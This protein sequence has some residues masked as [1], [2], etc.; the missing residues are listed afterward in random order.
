MRSLDLTNQKMIDARQAFMDALAKND[1]DALMDAMQ[2]M[3]DAHAQ[4]LMADY[5]DLRQETD[6]RILAQRGVR[7]LT[8]EERKYYQKVVEAMKSPDP[9]QAITNLEA[10]M[11]TTIIDAVFEDLET[12]H[13]LLS[14]IDFIP[15]NGLIEMIMNTDT[16]QMATWGPL[17]G[18][19]TKELQTGFKKEATNLFKLSAFLPVC[20]AM[21]DLGPVWLD[22]YVRRVLAEALANGLEYGY[23]MGN[24]KDMPIGMVR[25]AGEGV[26]VT[27]GV[28]PEKAAIELVEINPETIGNLLSIMAMGPN[29]KTRV[30]NGVI[31][32]VNGQD[33]YQKVMPATTVMAPDGTYRNNVMPY[34]MDVIP[35]WTL[36][37]GK[38]VIGIARKYF[39]PAGM[40]KDG[41]I[42]Y[43]DEYRFL[44]DE[45]VYLIKLYAS[46]KPKDDN[47]FLVLDISGLQPASYKVTQIDGRD[48]SDDAT[49][50]SLSLG[51]AKLT[52]EF[53]A[54]TTTYEAATTNLTNVV[55][56]VPANAAA[57]VK[58]FVNDV[59]INNGTSAEWKTGANTVKVVVT[60]EDDTTTKTYT[61]TVNKAE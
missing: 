60:A 10:V 18:E 47:A 30:V 13:P 7:Q 17:C 59:E 15:T 37:R 8:S 2:Q 23:V 48:P 32:L 9:K 12:N 40:T 55:N 21:L 6:L 54:G 28:Y 35:T 19:I 38:A 46:G 1:K 11:P 50:S 26:T 14:R 58:V 49:L 51:N 53:A 39:A 61:V 24:G 29:G 22:A 25:Q 27:G 52:P 31:F 33:Y 36:P 34:P 41:R 45:R 43:S 56:A 57:V 5:Q 42:E 44:E 3:M 20:K 4:Q 16:T